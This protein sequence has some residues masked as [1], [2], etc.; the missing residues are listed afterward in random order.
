MRPCRAQAR[1]ELSRRGFSEVHFDLAKR[2]F[3]ADPAVRKQ[4]ARAL[5]GLRSIDAAPWLLELGR[6]TDPDV[7][8]TAIALMAT[9]GDPSLL[10]EVERIAAEDPDP[11]IRQELSHISQQRNDAGHRGDSMAARPQPKY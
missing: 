8:L 2:L 10:E 11:R 3:S 4:L 5:P 9:S 1:A 6:D 7:R